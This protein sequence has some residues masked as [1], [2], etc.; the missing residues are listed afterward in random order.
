MKKALLL[1]SAALLSATA[2]FAE[3]GFYKPGDAIQAK[4]ELVSGTYFMH[5]MRHDSPNLKG[6]LRANG[7]TN[8]DMQS[9]GMFG[10][11]TTIPEAGT[12]NMNLVWRVAVDDEGLITLY[13]LGMEKYFSIEASRSG[14]GS[15]PDRQTR[16]IKPT[17]DEAKIA[18]YALEDIVA[19][20]I[21]DANVTRFKVRG[22]NVIGQNSTTSNIV[23]P[24]WG[25]ANGS[26]V[27]QPVEYWQTCSEIQ[28]QFVQAI[29]VPTVDITVT[30]PDW[31]NQPVTQTISATIGDDAKDVINNYITSMGGMKNVVISKEGDDDDFTVSATNVNFTVEGDWNDDFDA[32]QVYRICVNPNDSPAA[33][34]YMLLTGELKTK[35]ESTDDANAESL[36]RIVPERLWFFK[37]GEEPNTYTLHNLYDPSKGVYFPVAADGSVS[38]NT[39]A[40]YT[41]E[42]EATLFNLVSKTA[43]NQ[44]VLKVAGSETAFVND[45]SGSGFFSIYNITGDEN[46]SAE[47]K[48]KKN[49]GCTLLLYPMLDAD[50]AQIGLD[51]NA[52]PYATNEEFVKAVNSWNEQNIAAAIRRIEFW[53]GEDMIGPNPGR[54]ENEDNTFREKL[55]YARDLWA[56]YQ[57]DA[58]SVKEDELK[59]A[60]SDISYDKLRFNEVVPG[61]FYR[62]KNR[63]SGKYMS[64]ITGI[65]QSNN[66]RMDMTL[67][68]TRSNTVFYYLEDNGKKMLVC[69]DDGKV[70]NTLSGTS[71][72]PVLSD[73]GDAATNISISNW[74]GIWCTIHVSEVGGHR[75]A[76][77]ATNAVLAG[78]GGEG[79]G[80]FTD[81]GYQWDVEL[82]EE[83]PVPLYHSSTDNAAWAS[84]YSP[85]ELE[86]QNGEAVAHN[87]KYTG[88]AVEYTK[89]G[90]G[91]KVPAN[92]PVL[93]DYKGGA[94]D[95][96]HREGISYIY[97]KVLYPDASTP[98]VENLMY[99]GE[100]AA[101]EESD[102]DLN[103]GIFAINN[104]ED[105]NYFTLHQTNS[106]NFRLYTET[107]IPGFKAHIA[108]PVSQM[109]VQTE[110]TSDEDGNMIFKIKAANNGTT[111]I[112]ELVSEKQNKKVYDLQGRKL[113]A[114]VKGVN[115]VN[116]KKVLVK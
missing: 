102:K 28:V 37:P 113:A 41:D 44:F 8:D 87:A 17:T 7:T 3:V 80:V 35:P 29:E 88:T 100:D 97:L 38:N 49:N 59:Q 116:G 13:S 86:I 70:L 21:I 42:H 5:L 9:F 82:V 96:E 63:A 11:V 24:Y 103:G 72:K 76:H 10:D 14:T 99:D 12:D 61:K 112:D 30:F 84:V 55:E 78:G 53:G 57:A 6:Y 109:P 32:Y 69:F 68:G 85:V 93:L 62:F 64:S 101:T 58:N 33:L 16:N 47:D 26:T 52:D 31:N 105:T 79:S 66:N 106:N 18:K 25:G 45:Y 83:L 114:P 90:E 65:E 67:D 40:E 4:S 92:T 77:G 94:E 39:Q 115:I 2:A 71:W 75:H 74:E 1:A 51:S 95:S 91:N 46:E 107:E 48:A 50:L 111:G 43:D 27:P 15:H 20:R 81:T 73:A 60:A 98:V 110:D 54:Y 34:R 108:I 22:M 104:A 36:Q 89:I 56:K 23:R 19:D